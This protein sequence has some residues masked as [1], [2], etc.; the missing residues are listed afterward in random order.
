[1][2]KINSLINVLKKNN[3]NFFTGVPDSV[4]KELSFFLQSK[5]KKNHIIATNEGSAVSI[6]IGN[7]LSTKKTPVIYM[8]NSGLSNALNPL[9]S[10]AHEKVYSI[11]LILIIGW[12]GSPRVK[13]EPQHNVKGKI[14]EKLLKLLNIKYTIIRSLTDL[15]KFD[16]QIKLSKK[17]KS[18]VACLIEEGTLKKSININ[19]KKDFY[20]L[21]KEFFLKTLLKNL[22]KNSKIVSSTGYNSRE[23]IY[24]RQKHK[25]KNSKDFYMVGG[26]GHTSSVALGYSLSKKNKTICIDGDGSFLMHLGSIKTAGTFGK[27]NFKYI[28]LNN[29]SHESVG[30]QSTNIENVNLK[31]FSKSVGYK[32]YFRLSE[33]SNASERIKSFLKQDGPSFLEVDIKINKD[34]NDLPRPKNLIDVKNKFLK[35]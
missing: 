28:L 15:N 11:P 27:K 32:K 29:K 19:K 3:S 12:R 22:Q 2:I 16:K 34:E 9:I 8:Q 35:K 18:I 31:L 1:M 4:L 25:I 13:D 5:S 24:L 17:N 7:Y 20:K 21:D 23:L 6:G 10:I 26:M 30:G 14:T 33:K